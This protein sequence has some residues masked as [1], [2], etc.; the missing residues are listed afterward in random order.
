MH[1]TLQTTLKIMDCDDQE[2]AGGPVSHNS[3]SGEAVGVFNGHGGF[4]VYEYREDVRLS[5]RELPSSVVSSLSGDQPTRAADR[6]I[7]A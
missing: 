4:F 3:A 5:E 2:T 1:S 6:W 7:I